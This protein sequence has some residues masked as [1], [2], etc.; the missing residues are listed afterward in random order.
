M[1]DEGGGQV[2][3]AAHPPG[4][5]PH[6]PLAGPAQIE[7][8]EH[9]SG[10]ASA[11]AAAEAVQAADQLEVLAAGQQLVERRGLAGEAEQT[12]GGRRLPAH[13]YATD[14]H[15]A[16]VRDEQR[17]ENPHQGRLA[18]A[19]RSQK[20]KDLALADPERHPVERPS[21]AERLGDVLDLDHPSSHF[22]TTVW[23]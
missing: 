23:L 20:T 14:A 1:P 4:V 12:A 7:A 3:A 15:C 9:L 6:R 22:H 19:V 16:A 17:G 5:G 2:E 11:L 13:V 10:A 18:G 21:L 8:L